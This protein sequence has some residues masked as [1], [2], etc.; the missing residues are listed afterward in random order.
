M[1]TAGRSWFRL[2]DPFLSSGDC[3]GR[4]VV[5]SAV[6]FVPDIN[7]CQGG[8]VPSHGVPGRA[9]RRPETTRDDPGHGTVG[10]AGRSGTRDRSEAR[11][12]PGCGTRCPE[13]A[14]DGRG[15]PTERERPTTL[16]TE[17][18]RVSGGTHV[19]QACP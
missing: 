10:G 2:G 8:Q 5:N 11:D 17:S 14:W 1:A 12:A 6:H 16:A 4:V 18:T 3:F 9:T 19:N 7:C 15:S 13:T